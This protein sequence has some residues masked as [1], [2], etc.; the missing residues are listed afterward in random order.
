MSGAKPF[1]PV[2]YLGNK[3][4]VLSEIS[5]ATNSLIGPRGRVADLF[6]GTTV[7]AQMLAHRGY[8]VS[9]VDTQKYAVAFANAL[10]GISRQA[11][12]T[13]GT[14][15]LMRVAHDI[16][17]VQFKEWRVF[18]DREDTAMRLK[19]FEALNELYKCLPLLW[20]SPRSV[21]YNLICEGA[22]LTSAIGKLPL[23]TSL[24]AGY[25]FGIR[26]ALS[27]DCLRQAA[28]HLL[29]SGELSSWQF[30]AAITALASAASATVHS[31]GKHFA[32]PLNAGTSRNHA[33]LNKRLLDDRS[34]SATSVFLSACKS[35][36]LSAPR[37]DAAHSSLCAK[38]EEFVQTAIGH[39][40]LYYLDP[41]YTAQ[42]YSRFYHILETLVTYDF[43]Q[44]LKDGS[45]T[46]GLYP[47]GRFKSAF[48]SRSK[49]AVAFGAILHNA[50]K[51]GT[52]LLISYSASSP[53]SVG[54]AR[55]ISLEELL[56]ICTEHYGT[57]AVECWRMRHRYRQFNSAANSNNNRDDSEILI[58]CKAR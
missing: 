14:R 51:G 30:S 12:E 23:I 49:A 1:R 58:A 5:D 18:I 40:D 9:A 29:V 28:A 39:F 2:Q 31:A 32:Q 8:H 43:P 52:S 10:L 56:S 3:L 22:P 53:N 37:Q 33:F 16:S 36:D 25:Y 11:E 50:K 7:V 13:I 48:S 21:N 44:M 24:F 55:M 35:I 34:I 15:R 57:N 45:I 17:E 4:R 27:L 26:Q 19:D 54:N 20:R 42:Q 46:T 41:P 47:S 38:A 6:T